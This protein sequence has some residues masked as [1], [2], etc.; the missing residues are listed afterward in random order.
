MTLGDRIAV[1]DGGKLQQCA[2][3]REV[4]LRPGNAFVAGFVGNPA[5]NFVIGELGQD[6]GKLRLK[7]PGMSFHVEPSGALVTGPETRAVQLGIRPQDLEVVAT[8]DAD[9]S[10]KVDV[11]EL[12]G[13]EV[14]AHLDSAN[15]GTP[16][17]AT[18]LRLVTSADK[19]L[20]EGETIGLRLRRDRL[21][22]FAR[23]G[24]AR[25]N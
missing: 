20:K 3:P 12:L 4:Y 15:G 2:P 14:L 24:G 17:A 23:E 21:H 18:G 10:A 16:S 25:L 6:A 8:A 5:M 11:I 19:G 22:L 7:G 9:F 1:L 13:A